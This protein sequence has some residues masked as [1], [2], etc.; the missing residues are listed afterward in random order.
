MSILYIIMVAT[1]IASI[2]GCVRISEHVTPSRGR[3]DKAAVWVVSTFWPIVALG[4]FV[5]AAVLGGKG[6]KFH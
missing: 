1:Y 2:I 3:C 6:S 4:V 5:F